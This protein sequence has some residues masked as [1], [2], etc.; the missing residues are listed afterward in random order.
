MRAHARAI[1]IAHVPAG[2]PARVR[3]FVFHMT[4]NVHPVRASACL[5]AAAAAFSLPAKAQPTLPETVITA[6]RTQTLANELVGDV[7]VIDRAQIETATALTLPEL[8][9][10]TAGLQFSANGGR[11]RTSSIFIRGTE[12]RHAILLVDGVRIGSAT[13]GSPTWETIPVEMIE[14][15]EVLRGPA[16]A[17]YGSDGVG[18]VVQVFTRKGRA[19]FHPSAFATVGSYRHATAGFGLSAGEGP[20]TYSLGAQRTRERGFS[21]TNAQVSFGNHNPDR[22]P[23]SQGS[24]HASAG[25]DLG[26]GWRADA[27]LLY[28]DGIAWIDDGPGLDSRSAVRAFTAWT[29]ISGRLMEGW[30]TSLRV[31]QGTDTSNSI[32]AAWPGDFKTGQREW[33]WQNEVDTRAG[34]VLAGVERREQQVNATTSYTVEKRTI[35]AVFAGLTGSAGAHSWQA[36]LRRDESSQFGGATTGFAGYGVRLSPAWRASA[37]WGSSFVMPSFNQLYYPGYGNPD[38][39]PEKGRSHEVGLAWAHD[40]HEVKLTRFD[41][42]IRG[43]MTSTTLPQNIPRARIQG[44]TLAYDGAVDKFRLRAALDLLD[45]RNVSSDLQLPRRARQQA[46]LG[47]DWRSGAWSFGGDLLAVGKRFDDSANTQ[48]L[49]GYASLDLFANWQFAPDWSAQATV[50]NVTDRDYETAAGYNQ[51][52]RSLFLTLRWQPK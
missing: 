8:L 1:V 26:G 15:I 38:L 28:S 44:W 41:N 4:A 33:T 39:Q 24:F 18:G 48:R 20:L 49:G 9:A 23:F 6:T 36:N 32:V 51:P 46:T 29:G 14:R 37:S 42:R 47:A 52:G 30:R 17:L 7:T 43:F 10:R 25:Y 12:S 31:A 34:V 5:L 50:N 2:M 40:G 16:S 3:S 27:A 19:G 21:A 13:I 35:D 11:G 45:P 22:D